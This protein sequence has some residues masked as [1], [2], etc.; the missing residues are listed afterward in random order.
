MNQK[1]GR[2]QMSRWMKGKKMDRE[3]YETL[4]NDS[5]LRNFDW[6]LM[7]T[8]NPQ[9]YN[10][11]GIMLSDLGEQ[12]LASMYFHRGYQLMKEETEPGTAAPEDLMENY[13]STLYL[14]GRF[15]EALTV[16]QEAL[17]IQP[18]NEAIIEKLGALYYLLGND[19]LS[20]QM[21]KILADRKGESFN[22]E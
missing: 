1:N 18:E 11:L 16:Y 12:E 19:T 6:L 7:D 21:Y 22:H 13:G 9:R 4:M 8:D 20:V 14:L 15:E 5:F 17:Q 2:L 10:E 3:L